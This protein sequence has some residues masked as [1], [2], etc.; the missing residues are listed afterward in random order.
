MDFFAQMAISGIMV[1][2]IYGLVAMAFVVVYKSS[3]IFNLALGE[4][5]ILGAAF[6]WFFIVTLELPIWLSLI[7]TFA[8]TAFLGILIER[9]FIRPLIGQPLFSVIMMT[10]GLALLLGGLYRIGWPSD[11]YS[12]PEIFPMEPWRFGDIIVFPQLAYCFVI[13]LIG[14][15]AFTLF[16]QHTKQGLGM[17]TVAEDHQIARG[18]GISVKTIIGLSWAISAI[19]CGLGGFLLGNIN[20]ISNGLV[21]IGL[22]CLPVVILGGLESIPGA[23]IAGIIIGV[24]ETMSS[25]YL[26]P[27]ITSIAGGTALGTGTRAIV[28]FAIA[29][30]VL[31]FRPH[32]LFGL[33]RIE[34]I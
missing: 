15:T 12:Y 22:K 32:G 33:K 10:L 14:I 28:P 5:L 4:L 11:V 8:C 24:A 23:L 19:V 3:G 29:I 2:A 31:F 7:M 18:L 16:F 17:R 1:G 21:E 34:R 20:G 30:I 27:F 9:L 25:G 6:C 26:D 13:A